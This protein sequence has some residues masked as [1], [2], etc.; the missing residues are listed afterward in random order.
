MEKKNY[1]IIEESAYN[2]G[3]YRITLNHELMGDMYTE[4]S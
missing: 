2:P 1:F 4:G 3:K